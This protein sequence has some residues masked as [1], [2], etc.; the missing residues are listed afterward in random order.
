V[1]N[2]WTKARHNFWRDFKGP[3]ICHYCN[4]HVSRYMSEGDPLKATVDHII[5]V[6][7]KGTSNIDNLVLSCSQCNN[8]KGNK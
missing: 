2:K 5:P 3:L 4:S 8:M 6:S 7:K 1:A